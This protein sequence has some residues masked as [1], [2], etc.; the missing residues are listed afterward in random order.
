MAVGLGDGV[1]EGLGRIRREM[2]KACSPRLGPR[3]DVSESVPLEFD[4]GG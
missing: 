4:E 3:P 2:H 1:S